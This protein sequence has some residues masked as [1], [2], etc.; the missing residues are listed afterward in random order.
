MISDL[1]NLDPPEFEARTIFTEASLV[2]IETGLIRETGLT[3]L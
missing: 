1:P 2:L 3:L